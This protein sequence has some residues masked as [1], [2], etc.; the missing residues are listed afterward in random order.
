MV[1]INPTGHSS[2]N[3]L[4]LYFKVVIKYMVNILIVTFK[5]GTAIVFF[6]VRCCEMFCLMA[7]SF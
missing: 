1:R 5:F 6:N 2:L 7:A 3:V 4:S